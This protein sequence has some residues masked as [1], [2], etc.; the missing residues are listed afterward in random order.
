MSVSPKR[1]PYSPQRSMKPPPKRQPPKVPMQEK[2]RANLFSVH[3]KKLEK[4]PPIPN[5][6]EIT[7]LRLIHLHNFKSFDG[8]KPMES[9][10]ILRIDYTGILSFFGAYPLPKLKLLTLKGTPLSL[11]SYLPVMAR[12]VFGDSLET[13][14]TKPITNKEK[15]LAF[16]LHDVLYNRL[17]DGWILTAINPLHIFHPITQSRQVIFLPKDFQAVPTSSTMKTRTISPYK[18]C[19]TSIISNENLSQNVYMDNN[20]NPVEEQYLK[21]FQEEELSNQEQQIYEEEQDEIFEEQDNIIRENQES[22][23]EQVFPE[24][25][26]NQQYVEEEVHEIVPNDQILDD[27]FPDIEEESIIELNQDDKQEISSGAFSDLEY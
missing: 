14:G 18:T 20:H 23:H 26:E 13:I 1:S 2:H 21:Q 17:I 16:Q 8:L 4:I 15:D 3:N 25:Y 9:L 27:Q 24:E 19:E 22:N 12:I 10:E 11:Y 7:E 5:Y 6:N